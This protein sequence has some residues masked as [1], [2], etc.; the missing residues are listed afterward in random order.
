MFNK[1]ELNKFYH[2]ALSLSKN[3]DAA[4]DLLQSALERYLRKPSDMIEHPNA[5]LKTVIR[6]LFIDDERR[7]KVVPMTSIENSDQFGNEGNYI[8]PFE[9]SS[10]DDLL[11]NQQEVQ[12]LIKMLTTEE[13]ELL[14]LWAVEEYSTS[15]IAIITQQPKGTVLSKL[16]RMKKRIRNN[17]PNGS[18]ST[19]DQSVIEK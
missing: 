11:I 6:N 16:H 8:E 10:M 17:F 1:D 5:Y 2:Y 15:E 3:E 19:T 4:Y 9:N 12:Q 7:K 18:F 14:Y 13:N